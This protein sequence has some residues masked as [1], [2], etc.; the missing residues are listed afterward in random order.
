M[1]LPSSQL[2]PQ[3]R[4]RARQILRDGHFEDALGEF[5]DQDPNLSTLLEELHIYHAELE[6]QQQALKDSERSSARALARFRDLHEE[7]PLPVLLINPQGVI[8]DTNAAARALL[9]LDRRLFIQLASPAHQ[10]MLLQALDQARYQGG[11]GECREIA[12]RG[13]DGSLIDAE[14]SIIVLPKLDETSEDELLCTIVDQRE[15]IA[16]RNE[17]IAANARLRAAAE[18]VDA[19]TTIA[20][21]WRSTPGWPICYA[22]ENVRRWGYH[23]EELTSAKRLFSDLVHPEDLGALEQAFEQFLNGNDATF[24]A[25]YRILWA[26]GSV[27]WV[28][29]QTNP[30]RDEYGKVIYLQ[31]LVT[32]VTEREDTRH[33]LLASEE[34]YRRLTEIITDVAFSCVREPGQDYH[35][36]WMME[37]IAT[38][39]GYTF[40]EILEHGSWRFLILEE[41]LPVFAEHIFTLRPD[42]RA[43]CELR[44][45]HKDGALRWV[46]VTA[47]CTEVGDSGDQQRLDGGLIDISDEKHLAERLAFLSH[48][49]ALT[50]LPNRAGM[51]EHIEQAMS[52]ALHTAEILALLSIDLGTLK[53]I[54]D[55]FGH[56]TGDEVLCEVAQRFQTLLG[57]TDTLARFG[58]DNFIWLVRGLDQPQTVLERVERIQQA[59]TVPVELP[60]RTLL[61]S[62]T[63]GIA[64]HPEDA[65]DSDTLISHAD[66]AL[67]LAKAEGQ[68]HYRFYTPALDARIKEQFQLEQALRHALEQRQDEILLYF[69]PRIDL[70]NGQILSLEALVRWQHPQWGLIEPGRFI[71]AAESSGLILAL[72][73]LVLRLACEQMQR[74]NAAGLAR[75]PVAVNLSAN[76]LYQDGLDARLQGIVAHYSIEPRWLEFE[77]TESV[78][79]RSIERATAILSRLR[80]L[81][82][83]SALDDFG[84]GYAS[85][86][87]LNRL[88][89]NVLKI[90]RS[91]LLNIGAPS[92]SPE[93]GHAIV[94]AII[95]LAQALGLECIAEGVESPAQRDFL[96]KH[97][98]HIAQGFF[99][100]RPLPATEIEP[101]LRAGYIDPQEQSLR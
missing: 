55:S 13:C 73:P 44:M 92:E 72:G 33:A 60:S 32:D 36:E 22:S 89:V 25:C 15:R 63:I 39:S 6:I 99:Y 37:S 68:G 54:N 91:F 59:L 42:E 67:H 7:L 38:L 49:D 71:P 18:V 100:S 85:L 79:M 61:L 41:D 101:L 16:Q 50:E 34:R 57:E 26:D 75:I 65:C 31:G 87:Y 28:E 11:R 2:D 9:M 3:L 51:R 5:G 53:R 78:A 23:P 24:I 4:E 69:Q 84:T 47:E 98:C 64:L 93:H 62:A 29:E 74:W 58:G 90:D 94:H 10:G 83:T 40:D 77:I 46:R 45:R 17:L 35:I 88:P 27:H 52:D 43:S 80:A 56:T 96:L 66:A 21:R 86:S 30:V 1:R 48:H 81:G 12:L 70:R 20:L 97:G 95:G 19:S 8:K 14:L 82:F 76:E